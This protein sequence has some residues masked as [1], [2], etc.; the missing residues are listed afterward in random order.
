M[1]RRSPPGACPSCSTPCAP[2]ANRT[3]GVVQQE[4]LPLHEPVS[5]YFVGGTH[6]MEDSGF[7]PGFVDGNMDEV[8]LHSMAL[9]ASQLGFLLTD[10]ALASSCS[11]GDKVCGGRCVASCPGDAQLDESSCECV[12]THGRTLDTAAGR[13]RFPNMYFFPEFT[14]RGR[15]RSRMFFHGICRSQVIS[16]N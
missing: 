16:S 11:A 9:S 6:G 13:C 8:R 2:L 4:A 15:L 14:G 1:L 5:A 3:D 7:P 10:R 12:C